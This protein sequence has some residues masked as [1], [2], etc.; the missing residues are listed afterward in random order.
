MG[1]KGGAEEGGLVAL[2]RFVRFAGLINTPSPLAFIISH[3]ASLFP[4][5][6]SVSLHDP[7]TSRRGGA[8]FVDKTAS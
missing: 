4:L 7:F 8:K 5:L 2:L 1:G 6:I 3:R